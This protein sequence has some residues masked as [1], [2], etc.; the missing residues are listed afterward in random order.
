MDGR[1]R[2]RLRG[3]VGKERRGKPMLWSEARALRVIRKLGMMMRFEKGVIRKREGG[4]E[5]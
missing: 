2:K 1:A 4:N 5:V 3:K